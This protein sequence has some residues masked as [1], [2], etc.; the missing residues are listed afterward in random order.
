MDRAKFQ[1]TA[2]SSETKEMAMRNPRAHHKGK[3]A[4]P[5][6]KSGKGSVRE[7]KSRHAKR[8]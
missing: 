7:M 2:P 5:S 4:K 3:H 1:T 8:A 6:G